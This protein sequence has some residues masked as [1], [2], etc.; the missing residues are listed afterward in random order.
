MTLTSRHRREKLKTKNQRSRNTGSIENAG[1]RQMGRP[2][3]V[4]IW[5]PQKTNLSGLLKMLLWLSIVKPIKNRNCQ[6]S[7]GFRV[8]NIAKNE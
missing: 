7:L 2:I 1:H 6:K 3:R 5:V 8:K 4:P